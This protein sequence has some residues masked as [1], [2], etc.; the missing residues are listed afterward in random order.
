VNPK[1]STEPFKIQ[2]IE[3]MVGAYEVLSDIILKGSLTQEV[4]RC[5]DSANYSTSI[6]DNYVKIGEF[7]GTANAWN[8]TKDVVNADGL[9][10]PQGYGATT[11]TGNG[12]GWYLPAASTSTYEWLGFG[13]LS[14]G[15][16]AGLRCVHGSDALSYTLWAIAGRL[17]AISRSA[18]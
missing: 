11:S 9:L 18:A 5:Y 1:N 3:V 14:N 2:N 7:T 8:Y 17:S 12:D 15:A 6:T 4:Y 16:S 10:L 13:D